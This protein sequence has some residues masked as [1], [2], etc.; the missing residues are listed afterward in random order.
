MD[1]IAV[2]DDVA[3]AASYIGE[4]HERSIS[5][6]IE[7]GKR[8]IEVRDRFKNEPGK[9]SRLIGANQWDGKG[10][11]PF[12]RTHVQRLIA[13]AANDRLCPHVG[14]LPPDSFTL[15]QLTKLAPERFETMLQTGAIHP[16]MK[17]TD[18]SSETRLERVRADEARVRN[19]APVMG[20]FRT[21]VLDP[22]WKYDWLSESAQAQPGYAM[23]STDELF[24]LD[25]RAWADEDA[26]CHLYLWTTNNFM[27]T[28]CRLMAHWGFQHRTVIT[29][30]KPGFGRGSYFRNSTEHCLFGTLG[31]TT[32]LQAAA[33]IPTHFE[34][35]RGDHSEKPERFY[36]IVRAASYGPYGEGNQRE[37]R[38][39]FS[40]LFTDIADR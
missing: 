24:A 35:P 7:T 39:D 31:D 16:G 28:A 23:Q 22:A 26:G 18:A 12:G 6:I 15:H 27:A 11:L 40:N 21:I 29:W 14:M 10:L 19:L 37:A 20:K 4:A 2:A 33:S 8:L 25:V 1:S 30:I 36:E 9:W 3:Q 32:T 17:R 13:I 5:A 38:P 34:A